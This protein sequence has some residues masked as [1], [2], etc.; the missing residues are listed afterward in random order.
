MTKITKRSREKN[1]RARQATL[2]RGLNKDSGLGQ[3]FQTQ[4]KNLHFIPGLSITNKEK[5][6]RTGHDPAENQLFR[7]RFQLR[8]T[9]QP[10]AGC[11]Q[12]HK[13]FI[14]GEIKYTLHAHL[15]RTRHWVAGG[16][17]EPSSTFLALIPQV[18]SSCH[19]SVLGSGCAHTQM[20]RCWRGAGG[21]R[22][23]EL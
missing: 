21:A 8:E 15:L 16:I 11:L 20:C 3:I 17:G 1:D 13:L 4:D 22:W 9:A 14:S 18:T 6:L 19:T 12:G 10:G 7:Y 5:M 23:W 2:D